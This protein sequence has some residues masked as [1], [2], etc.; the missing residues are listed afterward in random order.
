[1]YLQQLDERPNNI[2]VALELA[3]FLPLGD[4]EG[5]ADRFGCTTTVAN[6]AGDP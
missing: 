6:K 5:S 3:S 4:F 2:D 1:M